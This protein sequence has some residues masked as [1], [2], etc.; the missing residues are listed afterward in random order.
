MYCSHFIKGSNVKRVPNGTQYV[1][2]Q[3]SSS[4]LSLLYECSFSKMSDIPNSCLI[5][6]KRC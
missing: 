6:S 1:H 5:L 3:I 2:P 4:A